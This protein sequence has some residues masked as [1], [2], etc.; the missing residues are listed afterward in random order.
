MYIRSWFSGTTSAV[1]NT[2]ATV[3]FGVAS[4]AGSPTA[5]VIGGAPGRRKGH[6]VLPAVIEREHRREADAAAFDRVLA[7][8]RRLV[9]ADRHF[10]DGRPGVA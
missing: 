4:F 8:H 2:C 10:E 3:V 5:L 9:R 1:G 7:N 6:L